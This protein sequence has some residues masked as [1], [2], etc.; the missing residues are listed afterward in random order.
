MQNPRR[1]RFLKRSTCLGF[2]LMLLFL[3]RVSLL[4][5][6]GRFLD[7]GGPVPNTTYV[8]P[9]AGGFGTRPFVAAAIYKKGL[10]KKV[11]LSQ[12]SEEYDTSRTKFP[13]AHSIAEAVLLQQGVSKSNIKYIKPKVFSTF[14][15]A[16]G[17]KELLDSEPEATITIVTTNYHT[18]RSRLAISTVLTSQQMEQIYFVSSPTL[19]HTPDTWWQDENGFASYCKEYMKYAFYYIRYRTLESCIYFTLFLLFLCAIFLRKKWIPFVLRKKLPAKKES[20]S[21]S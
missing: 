13:E 5:A 2:S 12:V 1:K 9:L 16:K 6:M 11:L 15:E 4:V 20:S 21:A 10:A 3:F 19:Y 8:F 7:I 17:V 14:D 18:R